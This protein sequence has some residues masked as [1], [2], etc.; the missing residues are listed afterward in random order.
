MAHYHLYYLR[1]GMLV[2][3]SHIDAND[4]TEAVRM[5]REQ[6]G[7]HIVEVWN[8]ERRIRVLGPAQEMRR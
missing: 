5:A 7:S 6:G 8:E 3:S 4:D 2:G 1:Q